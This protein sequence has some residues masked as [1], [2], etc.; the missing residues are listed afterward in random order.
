[1]S[2]WDFVVASYGLTWAT[3]ATY[4]AYLWLRARR[5]E[6]ALA[7]VRIEGGRP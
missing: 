5:A 2:E 4:A 1:M 3:V 6:Q 7:E